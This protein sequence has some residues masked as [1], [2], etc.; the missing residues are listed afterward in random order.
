MHHIYN[1]EEMLRRLRQPP[2][3]GSFAALKY[4]KKLLAEREKELILQAIAAGWRGW[5]VAI[6]LGVSRQAVQQRWRR[7]TNDE[8]RV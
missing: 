2:S 3:I 8:P 4:F 1:D 5:D 7:L 6:L